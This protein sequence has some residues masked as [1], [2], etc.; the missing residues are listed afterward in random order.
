MGFSVIIIELSELFPMHMNYLLSG[1]KE[2]PL[3]S[4]HL[5]L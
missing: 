2:N 3:V 1:E 4:G 5:L